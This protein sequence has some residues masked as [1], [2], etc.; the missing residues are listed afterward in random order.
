M[1]RPA[2]YHATLEFPSIS[3]KGKRKK[4]YK[5]TGESVQEAIEN[6]DID[7]MQVK[8]KGTLSVR[9]RNKSFSKL[10]NMYQLR[11]IMRSKMIREAW[12]RNFEFL[13][14]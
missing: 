6:I 11:R 3:L 12:S 14:K 9:Y 4:T 7:W 5:G 2:L 1:P 13:M 10:M 8:N